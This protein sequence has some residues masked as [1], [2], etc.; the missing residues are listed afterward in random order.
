M[1][2]ALTI[3]EVSTAGL[4]MVMARKGADPAAIGAAL[5]VPV[6]PAG[7]SAGDDALMLIAMAPGVWMARTDRPHGGW[8]EDLAARLQGL[9]SLSDVSD[10]Y[11]LFRIAG[12]AARQQLQRGAFLDFDAAAF[13]PGAVATTQIAHMGVII[14]A[15]DDAPTFELAVFRSLGESMCH[16]LDSAVPAL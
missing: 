13:A 5:G 16:W 3:Y 4:A 8:A 1:A 6:P 7:Q 11:R 10:G 9:A 12:P 15:V 2:D 14:R